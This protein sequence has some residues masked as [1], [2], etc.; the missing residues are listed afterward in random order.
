MEGRKHTGVVMNLVPNGDSAWENRFR[1][2]T[3]PAGV[4]TAGMFRIADG[5]DLGGAT[6]VGIYE[7]PQD[8]LGAVAK[9]VGQAPGETTVA[10]TK[11]ADFGPA[12]DGPTKGIVLVFTD[13]DDPAEEDNYNEWYT[14]HLHHTI[15]NIDLYAASRYT[16]NEP[17]RTP[18]KYL[19][20]YESQSP[21]TAK[22][23]KEGVD[24]WVKG[25]FEG[26]KGMVLRSEI[27]AT[28][29]D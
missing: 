15:E 26:P 20:I 17:A 13:C 24:W 18:S 3:L 23:Q 21:D 22:V 1:N 6:H 29:I 25:G 12:G 19:A 14:G 11:F 28:R 9:H 5:Y 10:F 16:S 8:D 2:Q 7:S 4:K 27:P